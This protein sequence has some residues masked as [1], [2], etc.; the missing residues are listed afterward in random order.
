MLERGPGLMAAALSNPPGALDPAV[1]NGRRW[2]CAEVPAVNG[3]G[4]ARAVAGLMAALAEGRLLSA[5]T[6]Q[7]LASPV[8]E[9]WDRVVGSR[10]RWGLGVGVDGDGFGMGGLGGSVGWWSRS[11]AYAAAFVTGH[12]AD[13]ERGE[14]LE[15]AVRE[16][17]ALPPAL[18]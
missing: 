14:R 17:L 8:A 16:A 4:S 2:R 1:V 5:A 15:A 18:A 11:G 12:V 13:H 6:R 10:C 7:A 3:H 9:G